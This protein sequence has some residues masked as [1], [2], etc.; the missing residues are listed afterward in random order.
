MACMDSYGYEGESAAKDICLLNFQTLK[1]YS[2]Q[3]HCISHYIGDYYVQVDGRDGEE[4][5]IT[6]IHSSIGKWG[7][8]NRC[9][10]GIG[11]QV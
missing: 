7:T 2:L 10:N 1:L 5:E 4:L 11:K 3:D 8:D 6:G 9:C